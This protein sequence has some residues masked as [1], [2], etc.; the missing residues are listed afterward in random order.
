[1]DDKFA[2]EQLQVDARQ[3]VNLDLTAAIGLAETLGLEDNVSHRSHPCLRSPTLW[4]TR[5]TAI[6]QDQGAV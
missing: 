5:R 2:G 6:D 3:S 4:A 1:M